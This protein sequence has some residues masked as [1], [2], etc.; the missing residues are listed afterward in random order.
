VLYDTIHT[1][2]YSLNAALRNTL[3]AF[4]PIFADRPEDVVTLVKLFDDA[5]TPI[6]KFNRSHKIQILRLVYVKGLLDKT[7]REQLF[8][9]VND[10]SNSSANEKK[11]LDILELSDSR[12]REA[13]WE[14]F[15]NPPSNLSSK[16]LEIMMEGF[17]NRHNVNKNEGYVKKF[18]DSLLTVYEKSTYDYFSTFYKALFPKQSENYQEI[19]DNIEQ[20]LQT[21]PKKYTPLLKSLSESQEEMETI[22]TNKTLCTMNRLEASTNFSWIKTSRVLGMSQTSETLRESL[23]SE[24]PVEQ[25]TL[26]VQQTE[27]KPFHLQETLK[28]SYTVNSPRQEATKRSINPALFQSQDQSESSHDLTQDLATSSILQKENDKEEVKNETEREEGMETMRTSQSEDTFK[29]HSLRLGLEER[30]ERSEILEEISILS[31]ERDEDDEEEATRN[32]LRKH[33]KKQASFSRGESIFKEWIPNT[34]SR[35]T[36]MFKAD[37]TNFSIEKYVPSTSE[38]I[39]LI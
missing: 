7:E 23:V 17:N 12:A 36:E 13:V 14:T 38:V 34:K 26:P 1:K 16:V 3:R 11:R 22:R 15:V 6:G 37:L 39:V 8:D 20:L 31:G 35:F 29:G 10:N 28:T 24:H 25:I 18:F 4:L 2:D 27:F 19:F 33:W 32:I 9:G 21:V 5:N 30:S